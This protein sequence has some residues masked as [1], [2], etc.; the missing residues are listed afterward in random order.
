MFRDGQLQSRMSEEDF[1]LAVKT[2]NGDSC[3]VAPTGATSRAPG[4]RST[5]ALAPIQYN[6]YPHMAM[7]P[8][9]LGDMP[10]YYNPQQMMGQV[11]YPMG[12]GGQMVMGSG[13]GAKALTRSSCG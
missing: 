10:G 2:F 1:K 5:H 4:L 6:P 13:F 9:Q 3:L 8:P 7:A 12:G 11:M